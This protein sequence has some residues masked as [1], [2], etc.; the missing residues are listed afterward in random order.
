M[1][2]K[3]IVAAVGRPNV[4]K[5]TFFN[6]MAGRRI[7][8]V[9]DRPG[10]TRD[11]I[12]ADVEWRG[13]EFSLIDTGGLDPHSDDPM[14]ARIREQ[15]ELACDVADAI[16]FM[17]DARVGLMPDDVD[18]A[19]R[20]RKSG[21]PIL[22]VAN[23]VDGIGQ[24]DYLEFCGLGLGDPIPISASNGLNM[25]DLCDEILNAL[26]DVGPVAEPSPALSVAIVGR[27]NAGK[28]SLVNRILGENRVIVTELPGT[29]RDSI[30]TPFEMDGKAYRL[31]DTAGIR[32]KSRV[33]E[34]V[35]YYSAIR[36]ISA[37]ES[38]DAVAIVIDATEGV[39]EQD[40]KICGLAH[41]RLKPSVVL[42][43]KWDLV[44]KD[45][46]AVDA[47]NMR[48]DSELKFMSYRKTLYISALTGQRV[49][50]ALALLEESHANASRRI[51]T[52]V[53][54]EVIGDAM[55][56]N[57]PP[58]AGRGKLKIYYCAQTSTNPPV[59]ALFANDEKLMHFS[60][61]RY[62]ENALRKAFDFSGTPI[63]VSVRTR[64]DGKA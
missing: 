18:I 16:V 22:L 10:I 3:P 9:D 19:K 6:R 36:A 1:T 50:K 28:S 54:N 63:R 45:S 34:D 14:R 20:L 8:I 52:G 29:T 7:S 27:P 46:R 42:V 57:E 61:R 60:Y 4:G 2:K 55:A 31:I 48:L 38:A 35:E 15:A 37:I 44:E 33:S 23:K 17:T 11:R 58:G 47:F 13:R 62:L 25:G 12:Y 56:A 32:K 49:N 24:T 30:D 5:S 39:A 51:P 26:G 53:L 43:N 59:F 21:K 41:D 40:V 64:S